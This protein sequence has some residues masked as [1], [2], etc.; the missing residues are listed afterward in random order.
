MSENRFVL[1]VIGIG[2]IPII[3][4]VCAFPL[5]DILYFLRFE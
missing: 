4:I 2:L 1:N 3:I 5:T